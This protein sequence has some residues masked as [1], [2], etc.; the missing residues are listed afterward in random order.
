[1][2]ASVSLFALCQQPSEEHQFSFKGAYLGMPL[3]QF[4]VLNKQEVWINTGDP[5]KRKDNDKAQVVYSPLCSDQYDIGSLMNSLGFIGHASLGAP[6][7]KPQQNEIVCFTTSGSSDY[8]INQHPKE[9]PGFNPEGRTVAGE[10]AINLHYRFVQGK[11]YG[12]HMWFVTSEMPAILSAFSQK[13]GSPQEVSA[14]N[15]QNGFGATWQGEVYTWRHDSQI[16][17]LRMGSG[18]G[19]GQ[20]PFEFNGSAGVDIVDTSVAENII[21]VPRGRVDF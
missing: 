16:I 20:S 1:M 3:D 18:R 13:Y 8:T 6:I 11:L 15:F 2:F 21:N 10:K 4:R 9:L 19:P 7:N 14:E 17:K 5:H 12:I